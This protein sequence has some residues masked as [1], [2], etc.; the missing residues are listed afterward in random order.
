MNVLD[1]IFARKREEVEAAQARVSLAELRRMVQDAPEKVGFRDA[2][3]NSPKELSLI[4][5][6]KKASPSRGMI[7][8][9]FDPVA[10]AE[11]YKRAGA[12][13]LSVLTDR[14]YFQ[15]DPEYLTAAKK[16]TNLPCLRKDFVYDAYQI[17]EARALGADCILLIVAGLEKTQIKDL[18]AVS[19]ELG[20]DTLVEVHDR[21]EAEIAAEL[22]CNLVGV[23][24][25][26][27]RDFKT[28]LA[29]SEEL[30]PFLKK[31]LPEAVL[32]SESALENLNDLAR[33]K[34]AGAR[35][36]LI[37]TAFCASP[38]IEV[39]VKEVMGW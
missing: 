5:E 2:L 21:P 26:N 16:A 15:G 35:A 14:D 19:K 31:S 34:L 27:L 30:L 10:I 23:N 7:R 22:G 20:M 36:V 29:V 6:V 9:N 12:S 32:V 38:E 24:N 1:R 13:C 11:E 28:D 3:K 18:M 39:K 17:Y 37:G 4:A 8:P 25:R 33:V